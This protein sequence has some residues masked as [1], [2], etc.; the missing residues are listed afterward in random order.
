MPLQS[1]GPAAPFPVNDELALSTLATPDQIE[2]VV[3][4]LAGGGYV[5]LWA[6]G[7]SQPRGLRAQILDADGNKVGGEIVVDG[8][9]NNFRDYRIEALAGGG[10]AI[11]WQDDIPGDGGGGSQG[12]FGVK[13]Q[14][15]SAAG[16]PAGGPIQVNTT[17]VQDQQLVEIVELADGKFVVTWTHAGN[18][19]RARI[20]AADGSAFSAEFRVNTTDTFEQTLAKVTA[21]QNGGFVV[22]WEDHS[23]AGAGGQFGNTAQIDVRAQYFDGSGAAVGGEI[24]VNSTTAGK[25]GDHRLITLDGGNVLIAWNDYSEGNF[26]GDVRAQIIDAAGNKVGGEFLINADTAGRQITPVLQSLAS[27]GFVAAWL[28]DTGQVQPLVQVFAADGSRVGAEIEVRPPDTVTRGV[29]TIVRLADGGFAIGFDRSPSNDQN[30]LDSFVQV[31]T[32]SGIPVG[33]P[34]QLHANAAGNQSLGPL[35]AFA[36][37]ADGRLLTVWM[38]GTTAGSDDTDL[39]SRLFDSANFQTGT[40]SPETLTGTAGIDV[41]YG[42]GGDDDISG[43]GGNDYLV[44]GA[45]VDQMDGGAGNDTYYVDDAAD[46]VVEAAGQGNDRIAA[47]VTYIL[48]AGLEIETLEALNLT[49]TNAMDLQG[50]DLAQTIIGNAGVNILRGQAGDDVLLGLG[51]N[52]YLAGGTG[53]DRMFGGTGN[54]TF[55]VD[56]AGDVVIEGG[57]EGVDRVAAIVSYQLAGGADVQ[58]LEAVTLGD[59]APLQLVGNEIG[60]VVVGNAGDNLLDGGG[61]RDELIGLGGADTF[62]FATALGLGNIDHIQDFVSGTDRFA[63]DDAVFTALTAGPLPAGAFVVGTA[64]LDADDRIVYDQA[65]GRLLYDSDGNGAAAA[66]AFA[67]VT[68]GLTLTASDFVVI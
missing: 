36:I 20:F 60:Q 2:P 11:V 46:V 13:A 44:G 6:S 18:D 37:G 59:T 62:R 30:N 54:D 63:L 52:D 26:A 23:G 31:F 22:A 66:V 58:I 40:D 45:G 39:R 68:P 12:A 9:T 14:L 47:S 33:G 42:L 25:Q 53:A 10:F 34:V 5:V 65:A 19:V 17:V 57:G 35:G 41:I 21:L 28:D 61:G 3:A 49:D 4:A 24:L 16:V 56:D 67:T 32:E 51:G 7:A 27:G 15:Y 29:Q 64:A 48:G 55:Y 50:N 8:S 1:T 38:E 43:L